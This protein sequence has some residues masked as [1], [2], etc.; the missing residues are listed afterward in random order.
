MKPIEQVEMT[1]LIFIKFRPSVE[2]SGARFR[3]CFVITHPSDIRLWN[4]LSLYMDPAAYCVSIF[5]T[6]SIS[7]FL[8]ECPSHLPHY[9]M[10]LT[11]RFTI[12]LCFILSLL[13]CEKQSVF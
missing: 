3:T 12:I 6:G 10:H 11:K 8:R 13:K 7:W 2:V 1:S 4:A 9:S 5:K